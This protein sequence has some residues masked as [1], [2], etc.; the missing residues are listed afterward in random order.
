MTG[1]IVWWTLTVFGVSY[2]GGDETFVA[3]FVETGL[4]DERECHQRAGDYVMLLRVV[5]KTSAR[6]T[7]R[8]QYEC[9]SMTFDQHGNRV[10]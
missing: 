6:D 9:T 10:R 3:P 7:V 5:V 8:P 2:A 1:A 4:A